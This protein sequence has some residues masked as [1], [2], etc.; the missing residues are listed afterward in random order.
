[1]VSTG[2]QG[3][4]QGFRARFHGWLEAYRPFALGWEWRIGECLLDEDCSAWG[5]CRLGVCCNSR[6]CISACHQH[7]SSE[8]SQR[9]PCSLGPPWTSLVE[10]LGPPS[11]E[12]LQRWHSKKR[13]QVRVSHNLCRFLNL[14]PQ[15]I[16][17]TILFVVELTVRLIAYQWSFFVGDAWLRLGVQRC[18]AAGLRNWQYSRLKQGPRSFRLVGRYHQMVYRKDMSRDP[19]NHRTR[20]V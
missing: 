13:G 18:G 15:N 6:P 8:S 3:F 1:M 5:F 4:R 7:P 10:S 14:T 12:A 19:V 17:F 2:V 9:S 16:T 11:P 20:L